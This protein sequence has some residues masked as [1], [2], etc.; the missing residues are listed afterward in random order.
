MTFT[1]RLPAHRP[2]SIGEM[3]TQEFME[4]L[5]IAQGNLATAMGVGRK[6]VNEL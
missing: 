3:L 6:T 4:P 5:N 2:T 1:L